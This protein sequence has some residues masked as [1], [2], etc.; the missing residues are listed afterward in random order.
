MCQHNQRAARERQYP[1]E[2]IIETLPP[3]ACRTTAGSDAPQQRKLESNALVVLHPDIHV[4][5]AFLLLLLLLLLVVVVT[6]SVLHVLHTA[7]RPHC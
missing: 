5:T 7:A 3:C 2:A 6:W 1:K 4:S